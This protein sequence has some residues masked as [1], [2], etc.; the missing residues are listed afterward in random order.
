MVWLATLSVGSVAQ[1][2]SSDSGEKSK[3]KGDRLSALLYA[4]VISDASGNVRIDQNFVP[5]LRL[6]NWLKLEAGFRIGERPQKFDSYY[7]YKIELQTKS[8]F[9]TIR[10]FGRLS[11]NVI[12]YPLPVYSRSNYLIVAEAKKSLAHSLVAIVAWGYVFSAQRDNSLDGI[13]AT[14]GKT[15][16]YPTFKIALRYLV[17]EKGFVEAVY[18]AYDVFNPYLL[19]SPFL[20]TSFEYELG[21]RTALYSY[22]RYQYNSSVNIPLNDFLGLGVKLRMLEV[23]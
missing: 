3:P 21:R 12:Q 9:N 2:Y 13:P 1:K 20:Q 8:F 19:S 16:N 18:G 4:R 6:N 23:Q 11:E 15:I 17:G 5:N 22:F 7:H 14:T 10:F